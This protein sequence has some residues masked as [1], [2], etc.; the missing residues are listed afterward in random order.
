MA[1]AAAGVISTA[2]RERNSLGVLSCSLSI[3]VDAIKNANDL[4]SLRVNPR[5]ARNKGMFCRHSPYIRSQKGGIFRSFSQYFDTKNRIFELW[6]GV[7]AG[8]AAP[9]WWRR[10]A[11]RPFG[12]AS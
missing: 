9:L 1:N 4:T 2:D 10:R 7:A 3:V 12:E 8:I 5:P 6:R 11:F